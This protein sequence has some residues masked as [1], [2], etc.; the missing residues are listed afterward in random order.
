MHQSKK[1]NISVTALLGLYVIPNA[2]YLPVKSSTERHSQSIVCEV[3]AG[4]PR[5]S[6]GTACGV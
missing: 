1:Q 3:R 5:Y 6:S 2:A 4:K